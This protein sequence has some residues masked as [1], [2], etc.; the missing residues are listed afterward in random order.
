MKFFKFVDGE[1]TLNR[2]EISLYPSIKKLIARDHGGKV[3]GDPDGRRKLYAYKELAYIYFRYDFEAY[4]AQHGL[5]EE[6]AHKYA[7]KKSNLGTDY[8]PDELVLEVA[9]LYQKEHLSPTKKTIATLLRVFTINERLIEK[10][11]QNLTATLTMPTLTAPQITELLGYQKQL[12]DI[13]TAIPNNAKKL[14][15]AMSLLEEEEKVVQVLR[16]G[17][18]KGDSMDPGNSVEK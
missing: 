1:L 5:S 3:V 8:T 16:G 13:A 4:P 6:E 17:E 12:I 9:K 18:I 11:E 15:E 7:A 14:R 10:I 2:D